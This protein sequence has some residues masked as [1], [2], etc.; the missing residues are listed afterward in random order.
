MVFFGEAHWKDR[1]EEHGAHGEIKPHES[2]WIMLF[3][4]VVLAALAASSGSIIELPF[5]DDVQRL[6]HWLEPVVE[7]GEAKIDG[8]WA[9]DNRYLLLVVA[10]VASLGGIVLAWLVYQRQRI[11]AVEPEVLAEALVL[12]PARSPSSWAAPARDGR[13]A[14]PGS[15]P[16]SS[17]ARSSGTAPS[18][19]ETPPV[20]CARA[21]AGSC[22]P[23]PA[24]IGVGVVVLLAWFVVA[25]GIL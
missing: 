3:P 12:R 2:P 11:K 18:S 10:S 9:Y 6:E 14:P 17:T 4:L 8:T 19:C 1:A 23:T 22:A 24:F 25:R 21:R 5:G 15:T 20:S 7:F 13:E 16:T